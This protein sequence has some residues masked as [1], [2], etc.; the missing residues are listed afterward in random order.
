MGEH[1]MLGAEHRPQHAPRQ[2]DRDRRRVL[3]DLEC[4]LA[5][6][7]EQLRGRVQAAQQPAFEPL[8]RG[9]HP[10][11]GDPL[12]RAA[13]ADGARQEPARGRLG[14]DAA[15]SENKAHARVI[16]CEADVHRQRHRGP[17][18]DGRAV[19]GGDHRL[20]GRE[21]TQRE[22][23]A[24]IARNRLREPACAVVEGLAA[25]GE[26]CARAEAA[27]RAGDDDHAHVVVGV[28]LI[29]CLYELRAH[30][31]G[32]GVQALGA[33]QRDGENALGNLGCDLLEVHDRRPLASFRLY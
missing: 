19:D 7:A 12:H 1:R 5:C 3:G 28:G 26:I 29:E 11:S 4:Q 13:D 10:A 17:D 6:R 20:G 25:G 22:L 23:A 14:D 8:L 30:R 27:S 15:A 32:P 33:V 9:E 16:R 2:R 31:R 24:V 18:A 21:H